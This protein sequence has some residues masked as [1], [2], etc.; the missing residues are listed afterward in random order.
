MDCSVCGQPG[1]CKC[2]AVDEHGNPVGNWV[3]THCA[4]MS[5]ESVA[6]CNRLRSSGHSKVVGFKR[7]SMPLRPTRQVAVSLGRHASVPKASF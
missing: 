4:Y 2:L 6:E 1:A 7:F 3:H 5:G